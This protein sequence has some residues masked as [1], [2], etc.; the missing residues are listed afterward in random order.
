MQSSQRKGNATRCMKL[1]AF[2][3]FALLQSDVAHS[4]CECDRLAQAFIYHARH[5][6]VSCNCAVLHARPH[7]SDMRYISRYLQAF[8]Y[9]VRHNNKK[10]NKTTPRGFEPLRAEPNGFRV[11]LLSR[12]DTVSCSQYAQLPRTQETETPH[13]MIL[14]MYY[15]SAVTN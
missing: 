13:M 5:M 10:R 14:H 7:G 2:N 6:S 15:T 11:H 4:T 9:C 3:R 1:G 12:S 8:Q